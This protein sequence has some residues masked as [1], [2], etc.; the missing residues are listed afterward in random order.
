MKLFKKGQ[1]ATEYLIILA[2]V[3][4]IALIVIGALGGIPGIGRGAT[5]RA[6]ASYWNSADVAITSFAIKE[7]DTVTLIVRNNLK[8]SI[9]LN[10]I[11]LGTDVM[12]TTDQNL[13][14]G[15]TKTITGTMTGSNV[16]VAAGDTFSHAVSI[17]YKDLATSTYQTFS[18]DG[19]KLEGK[20]A[21]G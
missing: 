10:N 2:V 8:N 5:S 18:G 12:S 7:S 15:E 19:T 14:S 1:T 4:I 9:T 17:K 11:T 13:A 20:C 21:V 6:S 3:I 16:C